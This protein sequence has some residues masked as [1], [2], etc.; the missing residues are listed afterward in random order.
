[1]SWSTPPTEL[2]ALLYAH[3]PCF[4][5]PLSFRP[6]SMPVTTFYLKS[7]PTHNLQ[8]QSTSNQ[9]KNVSLNLAKRCTVSPAYVLHSPPTFFSTRFTASKRR[10]FT[11]FIQQ[12]FASLRLQRTAR[13]FSVI[14]RNERQTRFRGEIWCILGILF[15]CIN[16][17]QQLLS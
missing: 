17:N 11:S 13:F 7:P 10:L 2:K 8:L 16:S 15:H 1:M 12:S 14:I 9:N 5:L 3:N 4:S 6:S